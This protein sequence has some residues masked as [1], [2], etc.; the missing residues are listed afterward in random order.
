[1]CIR[2]ICSI[3]QNSLGTDLLVKPFKDAHLICVNK[4]H[5][6]AKCT[7]IYLEVKLYT[8]IRQYAKV[9]EILAHRPIKD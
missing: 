6:R 7:G 9:H 1:M 5:F 8:N 3:L 4:S 2:F